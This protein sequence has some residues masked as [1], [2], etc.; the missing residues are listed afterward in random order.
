MTG[1]T[2]NRKSQE[3]DKN[4]NEKKSDIYNM[5]IRVEISD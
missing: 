1:C 3:K 4:Q 5:H 2:H